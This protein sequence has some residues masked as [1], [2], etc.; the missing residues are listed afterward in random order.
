MKN[1]ETHD[2]ISIYLYEG[3]GFLVFSNKIDLQLR[4]TKKCVNENPENLSLEMT[5][6][7]KLII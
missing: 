4:G 6:E 7:C 5:A 3:G 2:K 1:S